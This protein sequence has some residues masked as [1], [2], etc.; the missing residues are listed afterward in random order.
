MNES[1]ESPLTK[2]LLA[3]PVHETLA[4]WKN[5]IVS[6]RP[7]NLRDLSDEARF[8]YLRLRF[9]LRHL[10]NK[11]ETMNPFLLNY[12]SLNNIK[13][14]IDKIKPHWEQY[15]Q[16]PAEQW[17]QLDNHVDSLA[18]NLQ[19]LPVVTDSGWT[20]EFD[21]LI[22]EMHGEIAR[23]GKTVDGLMQ[24][25]DQTDAKYEQVRQNLDGLESEIKAQKQ[26]LDDMLTQHSSAFTK[27]EEDRAARFTKSEEDRAAKITQSQEEKKDEYD[28]L[29][30]GWD[31]DVETL[32]SNS[33]KRFEEFDTTVRNSAQELSDKIQ[34]KLD[35]AVKIVGTIVTTTMSGNYKNIANREFWSA[36]FMRGT[37][38][39]FFSIMIYTIFTAISAFHFEENGIDWRAAA[40][41]LSLSFVFLIPGVYCARESAR[42]WS[43]EKTNRRLALELAAL[44]PFLVSLEPDKKK[45]VIE[46]KADE[47]FGERTRTVEE[48]GMPA[49]RDIHI[50][51]DQLLKL[52]ERIAKMLRP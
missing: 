41:R 29:V 30:N 13:N 6:E 42:H 18:S 40:L 52:A 3:H 5:R 16:N 45:A 19:S 1:N 51:G 37:A 7:E 27:S 9:V 22:E 4:E 21:D 32:I 47:Y 17:N 35:E 34:G 26:R 38:L 46:K 23:S 49:L 36:W 33:S 12:P 20:D 2:K 15:R 43:A 50:S 10:R 28:S 25:A 11:L 14:Q 24:K 39:V 44:D 8:A 48:E 31:D